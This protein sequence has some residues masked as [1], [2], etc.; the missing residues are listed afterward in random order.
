MLSLFLLFMVALAGVM[1]PVQASINAILGRSLGHPVSAAV[2]STGV[3]FSLLMITAVA[4]RIPL[5]TGGSLG[6]PWW[7]YVSGGTI[8]AVFVFFLLFSAPIIGATAMIGAII[9]G[10]LLGSTVLDHYG[11]LG[12]PQHDFTPGRA[13]GIAFLVIGV[14]LIRKF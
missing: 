9:A 12:L 13:A 11:L 6:A 4:I 7:V 5:P 8:G 1:T 3:S 14:F 2:V 10:Q